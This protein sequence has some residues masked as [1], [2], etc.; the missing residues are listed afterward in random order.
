MPL[1]RPAHEVLR[2]TAD[3]KA[4]FC[5]ARDTNNLACAEARYRGACAFLGRAN[6]H[7]Y[8]RRRLQADAMRVIN[9]ARRTLRAAR[10]ALA[11]SLAA[12]EPFAFAA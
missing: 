1:F 5:L 12:A 7:R 2:W 9:S 10:A 6:Q 3:Q 11:S 4:A 8:A